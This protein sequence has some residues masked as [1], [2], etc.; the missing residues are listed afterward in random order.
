MGKGVAAVGGIAGY[1][2]VRYYENRFVKYGGISNYM[3]KSKNQI[4]SIGRLAIIG[5]IAAILLEFR[6]FY[7]IENIILQRVVFLRG[8][9]DFVINILIGC[10]CSAI[11]V[12]ACEYLEYLRLN[13][14]LQNQIDRRL[15]GLK[16]CLET[17]EESKCLEEL[18]QFRNENLKEYKSANVLTEEYSPFRNDSDVKEYS[19]KLIILNINVWEI[20]YNKLEVYLQADQ[21]RYREYTEHIMQKPKNDVERADWKMEIRQEKAAIDKLEN[22]HRK[23]IYSE[24]VDLKKKI[25]NILK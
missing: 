8:H 4:R 12:I 5:L 16:S 11:V 25:N 14:E 10:S 13:K 24:I 3:R 21:K 1:Q 20:F 6:A 17:L 19:N 7:F 2:K 15:K 22:H 23:E 18:V 9:R